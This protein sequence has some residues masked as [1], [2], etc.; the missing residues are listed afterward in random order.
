MK[1]KV[2]SSWSLKMKN[3]AQLL[4]SSFLLLPLILFLGGSVMAQNTT[5][6]FNVGVVLDFD[7]WVGKMGLSCIP[8]ALSDFYAAHSFYKTRLVL[9]TRDSK[10]DVVGAASAALDLLKNVE[11]QAIIGPE[12]SA[13][14]NFVLDLGDKAQVPIV[15]FS[16][17]SPSLSSKQNSYFIRAAQNDSSQVKA[18]SAIVQAFGWRE[19]VPIYEDTDYGNGVIPYL[20]DAFQEIDTRVPYR[21]VISPSATDDEILAELYK[22]MTMQ[23]R[24]FI[25]HMSRSLCSRFFPKVK[26]VGMM[27]EGYVWIITDGLTNLLNSMDP[28]VI[29]SMQGV[30]GLR[31][32]VPK[33][34]D[35]DNFT[36]RWRKKLQQNNTDFERSGLNIFGL[37]AYDSVWALA[38]AAEKIGGTTIS[39]QNPEVAENTTDL[40]AIGVSQIGP[41]LLQAV[42]R[43]RFRGLSGE[44]NLLHGQ[45]QS[46]VFQL[47]NVIGNGAR[48]IGFWTPLNGIVRELNANGMNKYTTS[49]SN[50]RAIIWPGESTTAPKGWVIPTSGKK[51]RIGVPVKDGFSEFVKVTR[52]P[53]TNVTT[54]TGYCID[55]FDAVMKA[56]PYAVPYEYIP[57]ANSDGKSAGTYNDLVYQVF[58]QNYDAAV[59]DTTIIANRS[60]YVDFTLPYTESGVSMIVPVKDDERKNAWIF[61]KPLSRNLWLTS[62]AFFIYTGFVIWVLEHRINDD[63][64]GPLGHQLGTIFWF[65]FS[66]LVFA[67]SNF[68]SPL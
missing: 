56:L 21:S 35:L 1:S 17:T 50:L 14:A 47:V 48:E 65:S 25:V 40:A 18:I 26:E 10:K 49:I 38:K 53:S 67:H 63:F 24:V 60:Q 30:L 31:T 61:L 46:T 3:S 42:L 20:T 59:G 29:D 27:D 12:T 34:K 32:Y 5:V 28:T 6:S 37:W 15:S 7:T 39:F 23:T 8:M 2:E 68:S 58:L 11:V 64:R 45:L 22:L 13:Q 19:A 41:K 51:L 57:F 66:T 36:A 52:D 62:G 4:F 9:H 33:S 55:V 16:A 43:T 54:V 44:F